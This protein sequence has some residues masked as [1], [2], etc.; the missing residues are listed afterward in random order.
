MYEYNIKCGPI[1]PLHFHLHSK[2]SS[3]ELD[4]GFAATTLSIAQTGIHGAD[5]RTAIQLRDLQ[6]TLLK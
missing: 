2:V 3:T 6:S 4:L 5:S 1:L